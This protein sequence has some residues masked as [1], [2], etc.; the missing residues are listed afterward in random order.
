[1]LQRYSKY[2]KL[3]A[4][5]ST[6]L[7]NYKDVKDVSDWASEAVKW[8]V[9][10]ELIA[11]RTKETLVPKGKAT[12]AEAATILKNYMENIVKSKAAEKKADDKAKAAS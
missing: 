10:E 6:D 3:D 4:N 5:K 9:A 12:R 1:M 11:G 7:S 2:K 8:S